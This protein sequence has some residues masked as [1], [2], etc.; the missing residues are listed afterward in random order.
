MTHRRG[1]VE[2]DDTVDA[3][4][5]PTAP[6]KTLRVSHE[7]PQGTVFIKSPTKN[8]EEPY[9]IS[10]GYVGTRVAKYDP[11]DNFIMDWGQEPADPDN[12]GPNEF[13][14]VHAITISADRLLYVSDRAHG[15]IQVFDEDGTFQFMFSTGPRGESLPY[16]I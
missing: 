8:P 2:A 10:D 12:P 4:T 13:D 3:Q 5:A 14:T 9:F 15:R 6:W 7:L 1:P 11:D 16:A